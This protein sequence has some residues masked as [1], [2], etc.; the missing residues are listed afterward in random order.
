MFK[1]EWFKWLSYFVFAVLLI[2]VYKT[3]DNFTEIRMAIMNFFRILSPFFFA[4]LICYILYKPSAKLEGFYKSS[5]VN[6]LREKAR[7]F[8]VLTVYLAVL[9]IISL[10][11]T[12]LIPVL[13]QSIGE[14]ISSVPVY[15]DL[16]VD[17]V[18][19][20]PETSFLHNFDIRGGLEAFSNNYIE[21]LLNSESFEGY[22]RGILGVAGG[23]FRVF[24]S[25][26]ASMYMLLEREKIF[27]FCDKFSK[28]FFKKKTH[29]RLHSSIKQVNKVLFT[30]LASKSLDSLINLVVITIVLL[31]LGVPHAILLGIIAGLA[32]FIPYFGSLIAVFVICIITLI[33]GGLA[34]AIPVAILLII[35]QQLDANFIEPKIM[36]TTL[37]ISPLLV[38]FAV[39]VGGAYF[40][41]IGMFLGVP[42]AAIIKFIIDDYMKSR[43]KE[44]T[45]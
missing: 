7:L 18:N 14:L 6:F 9:C 20:L 41:I 19:N 37:K 29:D 1:G 30:F 44:V 17:R 11:I 33:T 27:S 12:F 28:T 5:S 39:M 16:L 8:S 15:Y 31:V 3:L 32:N 42:I 24:V 13:I 4:I 25:L 45:E 21:Q 40:G 26:I 35:F 23:L 22:A 2:V 43:K 10:I 38:I 36:G 34:Q